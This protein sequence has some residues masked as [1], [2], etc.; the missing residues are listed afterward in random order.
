[1]TK[2]YITF[3][4]FQ[5]AVNRTER[6]HV[7]VNKNINKNKL[8]VNFYT[9]RNEIPS[10]VAT[11]DALEKHDKRKFTTICYCINSYILNSLYHWN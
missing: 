2:H 7:E 3:P 6:F 5:V 4:F 1:M 8:G 11:M 10:T 9:V